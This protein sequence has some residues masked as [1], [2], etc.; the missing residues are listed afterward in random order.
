MET[1]DLYALQWLREPAKSAIDSLNWLV[2]SFE[3]VARKGT[4][5]TLP[6]CRGTLAPVAA[7]LLHEYTLLN[8]PRLQ[9]RRGLG[10]DVIAP[11]RAAITSF[12]ETRQELLQEHVRLCRD[13]LHSAPVQAYLRGERR[14][15][16]AACQAH[17]EFRV[18]AHSLASQARKLRSALEAE[19]SYSVGRYVDLAETLLRTELASV[20]AIRCAIEAPIG[21]DVVPA[22]TVA[23]EQI[24]R[25]EESL[26]CPGPSQK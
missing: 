7:T 26:L 23:E 4:P 6:V 13:L 17:Q 8:E 9:Y 25:L 15:A 22:P 18:L 2:R 1:S 21:I 10:T 16:E 14:E 12:S 11:L 20:T 24:R 3:R 5:P 19:V